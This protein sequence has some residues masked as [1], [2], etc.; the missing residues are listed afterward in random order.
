LL[1]YYIRLRQQ[2]ELLIDDPPIVLEIHKR[3]DAECDTFASTGHGFVCERTDRLY[4]PSLFLSDG[5]SEKS[6]ITDYTFRQSE[7]LF[8]NEDATY[9][10]DIAPYNIAGRGTF[11]S[12]TFDCINA[13]IPTLFPTVATVMPTT[14]PTMQPTNLYRD[15]QVESVVPK[16]GVVGEPSI[17][18][19]LFSSFVP[20][21]GGTDSLRVV[22]N[23]TSAGTIEWSVQSI[24][25]SDE[26]GTLLQLVPPISPKP[27]KI[28]VSYVN[29]E[30]FQRGI[31]YYTYRD[32]SIQILEPLSSCATAGEQY[33]ELPHCVVAGSSDEVLAPILLHTS[34][35]VL[36]P[37][38]LSSSDLL[39][40]VDG[41]EC[42]IKLL[43]HDAEDGALRAFIYP[44]PF[45][46]SSSAWTAGGEILA[47]VTVS[48]RNDSNTFVSFEFVVLRKVRAVAGQFVSNYEFIEFVFNQPA[49][50]MAQAAKDGGVAACSRYFDAATLVELGHPSET[51]S[52][53]LCSWTSVRSLRVP[54]FGRFGGMP[55]LI[56]GSSVRLIGGILDDGEHDITE[57]ATQNMVLLPDDAA[58]RPIAEITAPKIVAFCDAMVLDGS[59]SEG[60]LLSYQWGSDNSPFLHEKLVEIH[61]S[62]VVIAEWWDD[63]DFLGAVE[64]VQYAITLVVTD[65][66]GAVSLSREIGII[67]SP[68]GVLLVSLGQPD[69]LIMEAGAELYLTASVEFSSCDPSPGTVIFFWEVK[70]YNAQG[71]LL[72]ID[73]DLIQT[74]GA[75]LL[76]TALSPHAWYEIKV[77]ASKENDPHIQGY[78]TVLVEVLPPAL[79]I[80]IF[81]GDS[82]E[83]SSAH[84]I[85]LESSTV[86]GKWD[87]NSDD[88]E[89]RWSCMSDQTSNVCRD[90]GTNAIV[91][92]PSMPS[93]TIHEGMLSAGTH[94]VSVE[95]TDKRNRD[96]IATA[97]VSIAV[98]EGAPLPRAAISVNRDVTPVFSGRVNSHDK[99]ALGVE[100][101]P[102]T[103]HRNVTMQWSTSLD[104]NIESN[105]AVAPLGTDG[106]NFVLNGGFLEPGSRVHFLLKV[107]AFDEPSNGYVS[108]SSGISLEVNLPPHSGNCRYDAHTT[109]TSA[110][111]PSSDIVCEG[112]RD[113]L[114]ND[115]SYTFV[116]LISKS[117]VPSELV[118]DSSMG[119]EK[120]DEE[121]LILLPKTRRQA[122]LH[123]VRMPFPDEGDES[124]EARFIVRISGATGATTE[125][126]LPDVVTVFDPFVTLT[127]AEQTDLLSSELENGVVQALLRGNS[128][129]ALA[130]IS[131]VAVGTLRAVNSSSASAL[132]LLDAVALAG[133]GMVINAGN[134]DVLMQGVSS[135]AALRESFN[136][137]SASDIFQ[138]LRSYGEKLRGEALASTTGQKFV[139][140]L[141]AI[142]NPDYIDRLLM[143]DF[144]GNSSNAAQ[145]TA[146]LSEMFETIKNDVAASLVAKSITGEPPLRLVSDGGDVQLST[147]KVSTRG[148]A[149]KALSEFEGASFQLPGNIA[150]AIDA[151]S[152]GV[153]IIVGASKV[154]WAGNVK[155]SI[156]STS[157]ESDIDG[158][159]KVLSSR[160]TF[161]SGIHSL[162]LGR[163]SDGSAY[164]VSNL[165]IPIEIKFGISDG[166]AERRRRR[167]ALSNSND[168]A[169]TGVVTTIETLC[170]WW[171]MD[172]AEW[173]DDG[174]VLLRENSTHIVCACT[175]LT[176]FATAFKETA[177][178]ADFS[179]LRNAELLTIDNVLANPTPFVVLFSIYFL[180]GVG[181]VV[182][183]YEDGR[184]QLLQASRIDNMRQFRSFVE[185]PRKPSHFVEIVRGIFLTTNIVL[186]ILSVGTLLVGV[187]SFDGIVHW[188]FGPTGHVL[189]VTYACFQLLMCLFGTAMI[190]TIPFM[191]SHRPLHHLWL[192]F[193]AFFFVVNAEGLNFAV[194]GEV[195]IPFHGTEDAASIF[196]AFW[197]A[198]EP[199]ARKLVLKQLSS[200]TTCSLNVFDDVEKDDAVARDECANELL[201]H[202][203]GYL[204]FMG[205]CH[206]ACLCLLI[207]S[208]VISYRHWSTWRKRHQHAQPIHTKIGDTFLRQDSMHTKIG[209][210]FRQDS[211]QVRPVEVKPVVDAVL[212]KSSFHVA[213]QEL[214]ENHRILSIYFKTVAS[215]P[216]SDRTLCLLAYVLTQM[217]VV[218]LFRQSA[219]I[220]PTW[221]C[222]PTPFGIESAC[223]TSKTDDCGSVDSVAAAHLASEGWCASNCGSGVSIATACSLEDGSCFCTSATDGACEDELSWVDKHGLDCFAWSTRDCWNAATDETENLED[224]RAHCM[225]S[226]Q[227]CP[228]V[229]DFKLEE[230]MT[231]ED[232]C[233]C[234]E[235]PPELV[236]L[237]SH[238]ILVAAFSSIPVGLLLVCF[239]LG[240][241]KLLESD[242]L[243]IRSKIFRLVL[244]VE[245][246]ATLQVFFH[247][248]TVARDAALANHKEE[249]FVKL[250]SVLRTTVDI[251]EK[252]H[253]QDCGRDHA[254]DRD[255]DRDHVASLAEVYG[256]I[257]FLDRNLDL[258]DVLIM[259]KE[260]DDLMAV[261]DALLESQVS[262]GRIKP[263]PDLSKNVKNER[264]KKRFQETQLLLQSALVAEA[265]CVNNPTE[266]T[267]AEQ[268]KQLLKDEK[269]SKKFRTVGVALLAFAY[270]LC[271]SCILFTTLYI[272][273]YALTYGQGVMNKWVADFFLSFVIDLLLLDPIRIAL[274]GI[275]VKPVVELIVKPRAM[276]ILD[277]TKKKL[278]SKREGNKAHKVAPKTMAMAVTE[279]ETGPNSQK[280]SG[281]PANHAG[282]LPG[283]GGLSLSQNLNTR[284]VAAKMA[285]RMLEHF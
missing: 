42:E 118:F 121:E 29:L 255:H 194:Q 180:A 133:N 272:A 163:G 17:V 277:E 4:N 251:I 104:L 73:G 13:A 145:F 58:Q 57:M 185:V 198:A 88:F 150:E 219:V 100:V 26:Q 213:Q 89:W 50:E 5:N 222:A 53:R 177:R 37:R 62:Q 154:V 228:A 123:D 110:M 41:S 278:H 152:S 6:S 232:L 69:D 227:L 11:Y 179:V 282:N 285:T 125:V 238:A 92:L 210:T 33:S 146:G 116:A 23:L 217:F 19:V 109:V 279:N 144:G 248:N 24:V 70:K 40:T 111:Q 218:G 173:N 176:D 127:A 102:T 181:C 81:G 153:T 83:V 108:A 103:G 242:K 43:D 38:S 129:A 115:V 75:T 200:N 186:V 193:A 135:V 30:T 207:P 168:M 202:F 66:T 239:D 190:G 191:G 65:F 274:V 71:D 90:K 201:S 25:Y 205:A 164:E 280:L 226:C 268:F 211:N 249:R 148:T 20:L 126:L 157:M 12:H 80:M 107:T 39:A 197:A 47:D 68:V 59:P 142:L 206:I 105:D 214:L 183:S 230:D 257:D 67:R 101:L 21:V 265:G 253:N 271:I 236:Y 31:F 138:L 273:L 56:P 192:A 196:G 195:K 86:S 95:V 134:M 91:E 220:Q 49:N 284:Q 63:D 269:S 98:I 165:E 64:E 55:V 149:L 240:H 235:L 136:S 258:M 51:E 187:W 167:R 76:A 264:V 132:A 267:V 114:S 275:F 243:S 44:P 155:I 48:L 45:V 223:D 120:D 204:I 156:N 270:I 34:N 82:W 209:D 52:A 250:V 259:E 10:I 74:S 231:R 170:L 147:Q 46:D 244:K 9:V 124:Y 241:K 32:P 72:L 215:F 112:W 262:N 94:V 175:H 276:K 208:G 14:S 260:E 93:S 85:M 199:K 7:W 233:V 252:S 172:T 15:A 225:R 122:I 131:A 184:S 78:A 61:S 35:F 245:V 221:E 128:N 60:K 96:R 16:Y 143:N 36:S 160:T 159:T 99:I 216:R 84:A 1:G 18:E 151:N 140:S 246:F 130:A 178:S 224:V 247:Q 27:G 166:E 97:T 261:V 2:N 254:H 229:F 169:A 54:F 162:T 281:P 79:A 3:T 161:S 212:S 106:K 117:L 139:Q 174:C 237:I 158:N 8:P 171:N 266:G 113:G 119:K 188:V 263:F 141:G 87:D 28:Q 256:W 137:S 283:S 22:T 189:L 77:I 234:K 203:D 182:G